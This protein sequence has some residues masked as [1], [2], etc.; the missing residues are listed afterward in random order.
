MKTLTLL[1]CTALAVTA[2]V[3]VNPNSEHLRNLATLLQEHHRFVR[4]ATSPPS[5]EMAN[6]TT[7]PILTTV[8]SNDSEVPA[9]I[10]PSTTIAV[11][12]CQNAISAVTQSCF[13]A[14]GLNLEL[15][16]AQL[17]GSNNPDLYTQLGKAY[18]SDD[19]CQD[20]LLT[21]YEQCIGPEVRCTLVN[22]GLYTLTTLMMFNHKLYIL[23]PDTASY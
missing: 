9:T 17:T 5:T 10:D 22:H 20:D 1:L 6:L 15:L 8:T 23:L 4:Q 18:C 7:D 12:A 19:H 16:V 3:A 21:F 11:H 2:E 13:T 14:H